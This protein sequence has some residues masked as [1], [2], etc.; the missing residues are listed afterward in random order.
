M[1]VTGDISVNDLVVTGTVTVAEDVDIVGDIS[2]NDLVVTGTVTVAEDIDV[3]GD[4]N[5]NDLSVTG[6]LDVAEAIVA[7]GGITI[8]ASAYGNVRGVD[9]DQLVMEHGTCTNNQTVTFTEAFAT[10]PSV[11][12][13]WTDAVLGG[14]NGYIYLSSVAS[15]AFTVASPTSLATNMCWIA[16]GVAP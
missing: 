7:T 12:F 3:V 11:T 13:C 2:V 15:G 14:T 5:V 8:G 6:A 16:V 1:D 9:T 4:I 10:V